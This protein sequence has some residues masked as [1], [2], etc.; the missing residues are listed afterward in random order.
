[1]RH[2]LIPFLAAAL[3]LAA[4]PASGAGDEEAPQGQLTGQAALE[5]LVA[6]RTLYGVRSDGIQDIEFHHPDGRSAYWYDGCLYRGQWWATE[7]MLC[8]LYPT[9]TWPGPHCF[10][11]ERW[12][13]RLYMLGVGG[14]VETLVIEITRQESGNSEAFPLDAEGECDLVSMLQQ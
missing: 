10:I 12:Q 9:T 6:D 2:L 5:A 8:Y 4:A 3:L 7:E 14:A 11:A 13:G 1:M